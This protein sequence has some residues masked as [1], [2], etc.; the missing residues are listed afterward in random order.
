MPAAWGGACAPL[1]AA[2]FAA[3]TCTSSA[4]VIVPIHPA[5]TIR[6]AAEPLAN[7][8]FEIA[9]SSLSTSSG[10]PAP[11]SKE[12]DELRQFLVDE[13]DGA[14]GARAHASVALPT[15]VQ[16]ERQQAIFSGHSDLHIALA[17]STPRGTVVE[18]TCDVD[19]DSNAGRGKMVPEGDAG[20]GRF[21]N[22]SAAGGGGSPSA[23]CG[24]YRPPS[25]TEASRSFTGTT[26]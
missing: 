21:I 3:V 8:H 17:T 25:S 18:T 23:A 19:G 16:L 7:A 14:A 2:S 15:Q 13:L 5:A 1:L 9:P 12:H 4:C 10:L 22:R 20:C 26:C 6:P 24:A 11:G